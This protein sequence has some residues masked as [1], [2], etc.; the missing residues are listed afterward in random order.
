[1]VFAGESLRKQALAWRKA[2][3]LNVGLTLT[4]LL[5][6]RVLVLQWRWPLVVARVAYIKK[7]SPRCYMKTPNGTLFLEAVGT[8]TEDTFTA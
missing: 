5:V 4:L 6:S 1:M 8:K 3:C 7:H 2:A